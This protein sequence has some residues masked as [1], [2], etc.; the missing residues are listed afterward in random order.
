LTNTFKD[1]AQYYDYF[2]LEKNY[3][4]ESLYVDELIKKYNHSTKRIL[5]IGCGTG[6]HDI[7]LSKLGYDVVGIDIS[8]DM[9]NVARSNAAKAGCKVD[10]LKDVNKQFSLEEKFDTV[11][12]LFHVMS[13]QTTME[14]RNEIFSLVEKSLK[15]GGIFIF[16]FWYAPAVD[17]LKIESRSKSTIVNGEKVSKFVEPKEIKK[18]VYDI[19]IKLET[20]NK[21]FIENH[22]MRSF[23]PDDFKNIKNFDFI[24]SYSW[25][26]FTKSCKNNW[27]GVVILKKKD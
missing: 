24:T 27:T 1:Y 9:I 13:Y 7:E 12:S 19:Q 5:D 8:E 10:F 21:T 18:N 22:L 4:S 15:M 3:K 2:N 20:K 23:L 14:Q 16:D 25:M 6:L 26:E 11:I 17:F